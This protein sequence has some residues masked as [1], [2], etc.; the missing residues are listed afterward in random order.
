MVQLRRGSCGRKEVNS[1]LWVVADK[2]VH[3]DRYEDAQFVR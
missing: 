3:R 2:P 1:G